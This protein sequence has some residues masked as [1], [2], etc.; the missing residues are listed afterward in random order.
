M[1]DET[2][3]LGSHWPPAL[4]RRLLGCDLEL[5]PMIRLFKTRKLNQLRAQWETAKAEVQAAEKAR[6]TRRIH[7]AIQ[8]AQQCCRAVMLAERGR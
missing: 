7:A 3:P 1:S 8:H 6:D 2:P 5:V 4:L